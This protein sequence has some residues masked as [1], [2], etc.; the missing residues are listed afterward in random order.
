MKVLSVLAILLAAASPL[1]AQENDWA[2]SGEIRIKSFLVNDEPDLIKQDYTNYDVSA[3]A[4]AGLLAHFRL[5]NSLNLD[6]YPYFWY[7]DQNHIARVGMIAELHYNLLK[8]VEVGYGHHSWHNAD[9]N[10][11]FGGERQDWLMADWNFYDNFHL[12][13]KIFLANTH[14][15]EFKTIYSNNEPSARFEL[16]IKGIFNW[17]KTRLEISPYAQT[18][19][20]KFLY[21]ARAEISYS[22]YKNVS[23]FSDAHYRLTENDDRIM[24]SVGVA[25]KFK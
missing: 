4:E 6:A 11:P 13:P 20:N 16:A 10:S 7:S 5:N 24:A 9:Q 15:M 21:G 1:S 3:L 14:P 17:Q 2:M 18:D 19:N 12:L 8:D 23:L 22:I 25:L